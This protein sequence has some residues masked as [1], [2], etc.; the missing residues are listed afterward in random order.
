MAEVVPIQG[1]SYEG[2]V[3]N[4]LAPVGLSIIT[5]GIYG[6]YWQYA[7]FQEMKDHSNQGIG[8]VLDLRSAPGTGTRAAIA[9]SL[10]NQAQQAILRLF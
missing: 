9:L 7:T 2:K 8:G 5:L 3:R 6:L 1:T 4:V 10:A